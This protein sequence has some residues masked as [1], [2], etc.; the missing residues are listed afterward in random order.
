MGHTLVGKAL[1][2][3]LEGPGFKPQWGQS[4]EL[5]ARPGTPWEKF[6][7][8]FFPFFFFAFTLS[9]LLAIPENAGVL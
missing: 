6:Y 7:F 8:H 1:P 4:A 5:Q 3:Q 9:P 2:L